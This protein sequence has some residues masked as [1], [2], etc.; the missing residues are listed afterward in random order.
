MWYVLNY[1]RLRSNHKQAVANKVCIKG[2]VFW[3]P[4]PLSVSPEELHSKKNLDEYRE[5]YLVQSNFC[6][7]K[8]GIFILGII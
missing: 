8:W 7:I 2:A 1:F 3:L 6:Y 4:E 5:P